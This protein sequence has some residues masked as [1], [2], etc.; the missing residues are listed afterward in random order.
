M[1]N[2]AAYYLLAVAYYQQE[3]FTRAL[4]DKPVRDR[5][6]TLGNEFK[7]MTPP[8]FARFV[9]QQIQEFAKVVKAAGIKPQ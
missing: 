8:V 2:S 3:D 5:A 6:T 4:E 7:I 9:R 1:P